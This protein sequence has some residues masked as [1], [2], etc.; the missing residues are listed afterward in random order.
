[1]KTENLISA[2]SARNLIINKCSK[3]FHWEE[4]IAEVNAK[5]TV[6][7]KESLVTGFFPSDLRQRYVPELLTGLRAYLI[8][9]GY[10]VKYD[11]A[12]DFM[13]VRWS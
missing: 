3:I 7:S 13:S 6:S 1:M 2:S 10:K 4:L 5:I 12:Q 11:E 9:E 8:E